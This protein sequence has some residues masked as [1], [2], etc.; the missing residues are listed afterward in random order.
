MS[1]HNRELFPKIYS[2]MYA[3]E[4]AYLPE[5]VIALQDNSCNLPFARPAG[6]TLALD[7]PITEKSPHL[8]LFAN[9]RPEIA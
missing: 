4:A 9:L 5:E 8:E 1:A 6:F 7:L 2:W 3:H